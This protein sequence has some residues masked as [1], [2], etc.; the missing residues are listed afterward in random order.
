MVDPELI[1]ENMLVF[2]RA[3]R[4]CGFSIGAEEETAALSALAAVGLDKEAVCRFAVRAVVAKR[5][6]EFFV[7]D[8]LWRQFLR[9]LRGPSLPFLAENTLAAHVARLRAQRWQRPQ[10]VWLGAKGRAE[11]EGE[12]P[13]TRENEPV[14][15]NWRRGASHQEALRQTDFARLT[16]A[17]LRQLASWS[18]AVGGPMRLGR[19]WRPDRRPRRMDLARTLRT[20][21][22][23]GEVL[24]LLYAARA[25]VPR[26]VL[27][28]CDVSGS[29]EPY[30]RALLSFAH[31]LLQRRVPL[32][33]FVFSTRLSRITRELRQHSPNRALADALARIPD[34][35][36]GTRL[37]EALAEFRRQYARRM[38]QRGAYV[39]LATDGFEAA[40]AEPEGATADASQRGLAGELAW[41]RRWTRRLVWLNPLA[42]DSAYRPATAAAQALLGACHSVRPAGNW[43]DLEQAW[44]WILRA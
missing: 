44:E 18:E 40:S 29:M 13:D 12:R 15:V 7:F 6:D 39:L 8:A 30:S 21:L 38:L 26:P 37:T 35:A 2:L 42:T 5:A 4:A 43:A 22:G 31:V 27:I 34:F 28:L 41:L 16:E 10:V 19:R 32:E 1:E 33:V 24:R 23:H 20:S 25:V 11:R 17:E 36:G 9:T 14:Q 3:L